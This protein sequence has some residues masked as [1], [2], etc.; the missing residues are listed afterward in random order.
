MRAWRKTMSAARLMG[1]NVDAIIR[2]AFV[3][4]A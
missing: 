1:I 4:G 3:L 2:E